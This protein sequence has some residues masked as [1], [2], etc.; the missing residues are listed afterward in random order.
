MICSVSEQ[1]HVF[2]GC[3]PLQR[4]SVSHLVT[5]VDNREW[6]SLRSVHVFMA[7][8]REYQLRRHSS[9]VFL[10]GCR[11]VAVGTVAG[12][13]VLALGVVR[14][15]TR[16]TIDPLQWLISSE[17]CCPKSEQA[18][19][20]PHMRKHTWSIPR[21]SISTKKKEKDKPVAVFQGEEYFTFFSVSWNPLIV[22]VSS[23]ST[24]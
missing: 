1:K 11:G 24:S 14:C 21:R 13:G 20:H 12:A 9:R 23:I 10:L 15:V 2:A 19:T 17:L 5:Q 18:C 6:R 3:E 4:P 7:W 16:G 22:D 8:Q